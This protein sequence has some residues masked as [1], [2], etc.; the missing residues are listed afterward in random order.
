MSWKDDLL[1]ASFR[2]VT[3]DCLDV[4]DMLARDVAQYRYPYRNGADVE[5][6]GGKPD[7]IRMTAI[8]FGDD[9]EIRLQK[10]IH[11]LNAPGYGELIH[12]VFG[13]YPKVQLLSCALSHKADEVNCARLK[14]TFVEAAPDQQFFSRQYPT[15][16]ADAIDLNTDSLLDE[17]LA[18]WNKMMASLQQLQY[19]MERYRNLANTAEFMIQSL[20]AQIN[21][22]TMSGLDYL[23]EPGKFVSDLKG[24]MSTFSDDLSF[25]GNRLTSDWR[26]LT[27]MSAAVVAMPAQRA[28]QGVVDPNSND[29]NTITVPAMATTSVM[30]DEDLQQITETSRLTVITEMGS[31][32]GMILGDELQTP[33][34]TTD[35]VSDILSDV[36]GFINDA[37]DAERTREDLMQQEGL[38]SNTTADTSDNAAIVETL[39]T[40]ALQLQELARVVILA[41]PPLICRE[42]PGNC[43]LHLLAHIW[44]GDYTRADELLRLNPDLASPNKIAGGTILNAWA[45]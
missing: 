33:T 38:V 45:K 22:I 13:S 3:F 19:T 41:A 34:L 6:L 28:R 26:S 1:D 11:V 10:F 8:F 24:L 16:Q 5:D 27:S 37:I 36:R 18:A 40:L 15:Q 39:K 42:V 14:L 29:D 43:N 32:A 12:P 23:D 21:G 30:P 9:Y 44:Y 20:S 4:S 7:N 2:G 35:Q 25:T 31:V 17:A